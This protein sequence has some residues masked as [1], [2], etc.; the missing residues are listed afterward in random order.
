MLNI[1]GLKIW[2]DE[3][4]KLVTAYVDAEWE[5]LREEVLPD[6]ALKWA[7]S[8]NKNETESNL[9]VDVSDLKKD[10]GGLTFC[11]RLINAVIKFCS[12]N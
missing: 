2:Y 7:S 6:E 12:P 4:N 8:E 11:G 10:E 3:Y 5:F 1:Q 9:E